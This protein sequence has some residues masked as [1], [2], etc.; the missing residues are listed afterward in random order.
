M[1]STH[2][3]WP[4]EQEP[5]RVEAV[6]AALGTVAVV[7]VAGSGHCPLAVVE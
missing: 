2:L 4:A 5:A 1:G 7:H 3:G 6:H